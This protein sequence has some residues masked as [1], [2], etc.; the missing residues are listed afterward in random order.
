[1]GSAEAARP[2]IFKIFAV[3]KFALPLQMLTVLYAAA[4]WQNQRA[5]HICRR[6]IGHCRYHRGL[7]RNDAKLPAIL[8]RQLSLLGT[9]T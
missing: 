7:S 5:S 6:Y 1:M 2:H 8:F 3:K 4:L 9:S